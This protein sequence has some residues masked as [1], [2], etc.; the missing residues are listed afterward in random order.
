MSPNR[1]AS[2]TAVLVFA[3]LAPARTEAQF[4]PSAG[5]VERIVKKDGSVV[6][7]EVTGFEDG[8]YT[9]RVGGST[10]TILATQ[11]RT[12]EDAAATPLAAA[13]APAFGA[14][15]E[16]ADALDAIATRRDP[17]AAPESVE[18]FHDA[19]ASVLRKEWDFG[20]RILRR[21]EEREPE[22]AD[23][24]V[25]SALVL[26]ER[27]EASPALRAAL[28]LESL[29]PEDVLAARAA[30][31]VFRRSGFQH[32]Y[33]K[34]MERV[35]HG[36][37]QGERLDYELARLW[38]TADPEEAK[39]HW[40]RYRESDPELR[41][42]WCR[43]GETMRK[44]QLA[45]AAEDWYAAQMAIDELQGN[46]PWMGSA[47][48]LPL[49]IGI[50]EAR[51]KAAETTG[52]IEEALLAAR[53]LA[54]LAPARGEEANARLG[55]LQT[56]LV[57]Q[58][59]QIGEIAEL[60]SWC[61]GFAHLVGGEAADCRR[62]FAERFQTLGLE[63]IARGE[64]EA[65]R[66]AFRDAA[67][68]DAR[69]RPREVEALQARALKRIREEME[70][71]R[72]VQ[73]VQAA[74]LLRDA[75]PEGAAR[76]EQ[77]LS[78]L[79]NDSL[80]KS[81]RGPELASA[82]AEVRNVFA[83]PPAFAPFEVGGSAA[84]GTE[85]KRDHA[86][87]DGNRAAGAETAAVA[88]ARALPGGGA[89]TPPG[90]AA[91]ARQAIRRYFPHAIGTRWVYRRGDGTREV[92]RISSVTPL[93]AETT[94]IAIEVVREGLGDGPFETIAYL[95]GTDVILMHPAAP[96]GEVALRFPFSDNA[97]WSWKMD[98]FH[99]ERRIERRSAPVVLPAGTFTDHFVVT[100]KNRI[101]PEDGGKPY[102]SAIEYTFVAG[103]GLARIDA[104]NDALDRTLVEFLPAAEADVEAEG[105][106]SR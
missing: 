38:W 32:R 44:A 75:F 64:F 52:R 56:S 103:V 80:G 83:R 13:P 54:E 5:N 87:T 67:M 19:I 40:L 74:A 91:A 95:R 12:I 65:A 25:V 18:S 46:H 36:S 39:R 102:E 41:K 47:E 77:E 89:E 45:L 101:V 29:F 2:A 82:Q 30:A 8:K 85:E 11:V 96:P 55:A 59:M 90:Q 94:K 58:A 26:L 63:A 93:D 62:R 60:R 3:L 17:P 31:E 69:A 68:R 42:P 92:R 21:L 37:V 28:R 97:S 20:V 57:T 81:L 50:A 100:A 33:C 10:V 22:W 73:A 15:L 106:A 86:R 43:E 51:L 14:P 49:R 35:L 84:T 34:V 66:L 16:L 61:H 48:I 1:L 27:G 105:R 4:A 98:L 99:Y 71:G 76:L 72:R 70:R 23:P 53:T 24:Q 7:G 9:V 104:E 88:G 78:A 6:T 79:V